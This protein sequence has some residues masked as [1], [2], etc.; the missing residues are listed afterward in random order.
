MS[1]KNDDSNNCEGE[2]GSG[3][4]CGGAQAGGAGMKWLVSGVVLVAAIAVVVAQTSKST[5]AEPARKEFAKVVPVAAGAATAAVQAAASKVDTNNPWGAPLKSMDDL[6]AVPDDV[7]GVFVV[8]PAADAGRTA[9]VQKEVLAAAATVTAG[10]TK[11]GTFV[12]SK[13]AEEYASVAEQVGAPAVLAMVKGAG[14]ASVADKEVNQENLLKAYVGA[15]RPSACGPSGC[16][17]SGCS[18]AAQE[19]K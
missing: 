16:G 17:P 10:G 2:C 6:N 1:E 9:A 13:D 15:S 7:V 8:V 4:G 11:V 5:Q 19:C 14:M 3:C 12:M 18:P